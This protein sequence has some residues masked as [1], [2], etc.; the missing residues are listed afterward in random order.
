MQKGYWQTKKS[1][2]YY[3]HSKGMEDKKMMCTDFWMTIYNPLD[4]LNADDYDDI[5]QATADDATNDDDKQDA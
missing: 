3:S 4:S 1:V 2:V 5:M